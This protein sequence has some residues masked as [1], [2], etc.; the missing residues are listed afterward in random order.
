M[1]GLSAIGRPGPVPPASA[2]AGSIDRRPPSL[3]SSTRWTSSGRAVRGPCGSSRCRSRSNGR[4]ADCRERRPGRS[5]RAVATARWSISPRLGRPQ[6]PIDGQ[7]RMR[8]MPVAAKT[9]LRG[10]EPFLVVV[11]RLIGR[12]GDEHGI[13]VRGPRDGRDGQD[14]GR[15]AHSARSGCRSPSAARS[16]AARPSSGMSRSIGLP[17]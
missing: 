2:G 5:V 13:L 9:S 16:E 12:V 1:S 4:S 17:A 11:D 7:D 15:P 10:R 6:A 14:H 3:R 8:D